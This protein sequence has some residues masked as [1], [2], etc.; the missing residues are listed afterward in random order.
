MFYVKH[1]SIYDWNRVKYT[2]LCTVEYE[3]IDIYIISMWSLIKMGYTDKVFILKWFK[4][5]FSWN[6]WF[7]SL[8]TIIM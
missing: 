6:I 4:Q 1:V 3:K 2:I 7:L 8:S 5:T